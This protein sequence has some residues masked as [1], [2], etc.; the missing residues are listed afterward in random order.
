M[1]EKGFVLCMSMIFLS[2]IALMAMADIEKGVITEKSIENMNQYK[3][4]FALAEKALL[5]SK[6]PVSKEFRV[7]RIELDDAVDESRVLK[8]VIVR[9]ASNKKTVITMHRGLVLFKSQVHKDS[10]YKKNLFWYVE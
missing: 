8:R 2:V 4:A 7:E 1:K 9:I 3:R 10:D 6:V 5:E